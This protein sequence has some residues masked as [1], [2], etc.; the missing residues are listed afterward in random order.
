MATSWG[1]RY[2]KWVRLPR[3]LD[4]AAFD[5]HRLGLHYVA[6]FEV[7]FAFRPNPVYA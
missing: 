1:H 6:D 3:Q 4:A 7:D 5:F 2:Y